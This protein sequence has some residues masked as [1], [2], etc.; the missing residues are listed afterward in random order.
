MGALLKAKKVK[1]IQ[2]T[3]SFADPKTVQVNETGEKVQGDAILIASGSTP[4]RIPIE[5]ID[6]PDVMDSNQV[7]A[8]KSLPKSVVVIGGG[9]IG[10]EFAQVMK[11]MDV[12]V[13]VVEMMPQILPTEDEEIAK[14]FAGMIQK[15]GIE[16]FTNTSVSKIEDKGGKHPEQNPAQR[17][18]DPASS[19]QVHDARLYATRRDRRHGGPGGDRCPRPVRPVHAARQPRGRAGPQTD[20]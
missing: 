7:L 6:G 14:S 9:V 13:T 2:G 18:D 5:G 17:G 20:P 3:A 1:V 15:E 10:M 11:R 8:M 12:E 4:G 19:C 16:I